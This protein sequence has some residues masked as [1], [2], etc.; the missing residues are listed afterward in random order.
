MAETSEAL[1]IPHLGID[2]SLPVPVISLSVTR[3]LMIQVEKRL[4]QHQET[5]SFLLNRTIV[6][7]KS[8]VSASASAWDIDFNPIGQQ[9][10][11]SL[12]MLDLEYL[13]DFLAAYLNFSW[14][15]KDD[16]VP[17]A[18][19]IGSHKGMN[20]TGR[21]AMEAEL[22]WPTTTEEE[23]MP[24]VSSLMRRV[25]FGLNY[26]EQQQRKNGYERLIYAQICRENGVTLETNETGSC[27]IGT[28]GL[29][30]R[31]EEPIFKLSAHNLYGVDQQI[32]CLT[33][34]LAI[35]HADDLLLKQ[36]NLVE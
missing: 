33:G 19:S 25:A 3:D 30:Y 35:A 16:S 11:K 9:R 21:L 14:L 15:D 22:R 12:R 6:I 20:G 32:I 23:L 29:E 8:T 5:I 31:A 17:V 34:V 13:N 26:V 2:A 27:S 7:D 10:D 1:P 36:G 24:L 28:D 18:A 4:P